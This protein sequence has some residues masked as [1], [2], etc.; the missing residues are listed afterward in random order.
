MGGPVLWR[1]ANARMPGKESRWM[2]D[3]HMTVC[4]PHVKLSIGVGW[5]EIEP[6]D[7]QTFGGASEQACMEWGASKQARLE[8][9]CR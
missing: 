9:P 5:L 7:C 8:R 3:R 2:A 4:M 1:T 6:V